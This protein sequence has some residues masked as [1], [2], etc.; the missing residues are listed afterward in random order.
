MIQVALDIYSSA[1]QDA[2]EDVGRRFPDSS[3][4][5]LGGIGFVGEEYLFVKREIEDFAYQSSGLTMDYYRTYNAS[6][7]HASSMRALFDSIE[8]V[9][10][11]DLVACDTPGTNWVHNGRLSD[12]VRWTGDLAGVQVVLGETSN[13]SRYVPGCSFSSLLPSKSSAASW[14]TVC[15]V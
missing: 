2:P 8:D 9:L 5:D 4:V 1:L 15:R 7:S 10:L 12:Y 3:P 6:L 13:S 14:S 11:P